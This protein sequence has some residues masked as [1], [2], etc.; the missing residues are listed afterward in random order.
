MYPKHEYPFNIIKLQT[1]FKPKKKEKIESYIS[2]ATGNS[3]LQKQVNNS[4]G[5]RTY[6]S[7]N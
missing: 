2:K 5:I 6:S 7:S 1:S 3:S 4:R